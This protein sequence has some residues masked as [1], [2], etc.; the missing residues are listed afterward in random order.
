MRQKN[1]TSYKLKRK[2]VS[3]LNASLPEKPNEESP[4]LLC[5][6]NW[7]RH[8][9]VDLCFYTCFGGEESRISH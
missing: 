7:P 8:N 3:V 1:P 6:D 5:S 4:A 2:H 9:Q